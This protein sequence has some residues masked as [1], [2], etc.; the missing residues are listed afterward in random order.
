MDFLDAEES[1]LS[2]DV[3]GGL[4]PHSGVGIAG[5]SFWA[6]LAFVVYGGMAAVGF[7]PYRAPCKRSPSHSRRD[8]DVTIINF[9]KISKLFYV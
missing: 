6:A 5:G 4:Y 2:C 9:C 8:G 1:H 7:V 3:E